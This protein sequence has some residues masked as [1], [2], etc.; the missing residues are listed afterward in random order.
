MLA[1]NQTITASV[2]FI[3]FET[4]YKEW[5]YANYGGTAFLVNYKNKIY[6]ITCMHVFGD[7]NW[8]RLVITSK[9]FAE[10][11]SRIAKLKSRFYP[12]SP[13]SAAVGSDI[14]DL[15]IIELE[16]ELDI[17]T[18]PPYLINADTCKRSDVGDELEAI[19][20]LNSESGFDDDHI[21]PVFG[22]IELKDNGHQTSDPVLRKASSILDNSEIND[23]NGLSGCPI[24]NKTK[25]ALCGM[26]V[27]G[28]LINQACTI[29]YIDIDDIM[30]FLEAID[31]QEKSFSYNKTIIQEIANSLLTK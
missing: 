8:Q 11:G 17:F 16:N 27:R 24:F 14:L 22:R 23:V 31:N 10:L 7:F 26:V 13:T 18:E 4:D 20:T 15:V 2:R 9:K 29:Y 28:G 5:I 30:L 21:R 1:L 19:G 12:T 3:F 6:A 25:N